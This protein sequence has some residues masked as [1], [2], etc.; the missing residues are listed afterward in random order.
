MTACDIGELKEL[1]LEIICW[2]DRPEG[3]SVKSAMKETDD[4]G[5]SY[6]IIYEGPNGAEVYV[7]GTT[8]GV[9]DIVWGEKN[10]TFEAGNLGSCRVEFYEKDAG[11]RAFQSQWSALS[12][13]AHYSFTGK[14]VADDLA[15]I[16]ASG[17]AP[18]EFEEAGEE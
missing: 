3:F 11:G 5:D 6:R 17:L 13:N 8:G 16:I 1:E 2:A 9:G 14:K 10:E 18:M 7:D 15:E 12:E 4:F